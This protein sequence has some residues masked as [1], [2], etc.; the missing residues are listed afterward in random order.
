M[1][2]VLLSAIIVQKSLGV[3]ALAE[4]VIGISVKP[5]LMRIAKNAN[6]AI[7]II[8]IAA[9]QIARP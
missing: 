9:V 6:N 4:I 3:I 2:I 8:A 5:V 7:K 1:V